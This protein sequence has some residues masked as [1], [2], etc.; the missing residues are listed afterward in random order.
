MSLLLLDSAD[1]P[2]VVPPVVIPFVS[3]FAS[4]VATTDRL[5]L[6]HLGGSPVI[7]TPADGDPVQVSGVFDQ[8]YV[9]AKGTAQAGVGTIGPAVFLLLEDLPVDPED[10]EPTITID[11][12][13]Y[14][15]TAREPDG[16]GGIVLGLR[17]VT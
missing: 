17:L 10:D 7:Y 16:M 11:G 2:V 1:V 15:V 13:T 5:V 12:L 4:M 3:A 6:S 8:V 9:L 14:R